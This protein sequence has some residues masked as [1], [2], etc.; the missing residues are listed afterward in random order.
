MS[1]SVITDG[2]G[3]GAA[4]ATVKDGKLHVKSISQTALEDVSAEVGQAFSYTSTFATGGTGIEI[5][6][7]K[8]DV[9]QHMHID[10]VWIGAA[11]LAVFSIGKMT[12]GTPAGTTIT[13]SPL[14]HDLSRVA[15][16][17][18]FGNASVTGS[19]VNNDMA[20]LQ[21]PAD[22]TILF[23]LEGAWVFGKDDVFVIRCDTNTTV[24]ATVICHMDPID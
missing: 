16:T 19:V 17:T 23:D 21:V 4:K 10:Q 6:T 13:G 9:N 8:N 20:W 5:M 15:D 1:N 11:D 24:Y 3:A 18:A 14:N 22:Q 7:I 12:S 2:S